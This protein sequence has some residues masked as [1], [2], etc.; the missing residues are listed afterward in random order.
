MRRTPSVAIISHSIDYS[1]L[2]IDSILHHLQGNANTKQTRK[3]KRKALQD[4]A[5]DKMEASL[6]KRA[7]KKAKV[8]S[9]NPRY[10]QNMIV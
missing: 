7:A 1:A 8:G 4:A 6:A 10:D 2:L 9:S 3:A 5:K